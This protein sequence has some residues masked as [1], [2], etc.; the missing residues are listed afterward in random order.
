M[1][2]LALVRSVIH[3]RDTPFQ[4][5]LNIIEACLAII[6]V[7]LTAH[8]SLFAYPRSGKSMEKG[9]QLRWRPGTL[10][11]RRRTE[12]QER[13][14]QRVATPLPDNVLLGLSTFIE[15][16]TIRTPARLTKTSLRRQESVLRT[17]E[18]VVE[19]HY[20]KDVEKGDWDRVG[21][22]SWMDE[23]W[24]RR[25]SESSASGT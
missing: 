11:A 22:P 18:V 17:R 4:M 23:K 7:P 6:A 9:T 10:T 3:T 13:L 12:S 14:H 20:E 21:S 15:G 24:K 2:M 8:K 25:S 19:V 1:I 5:L 16:G